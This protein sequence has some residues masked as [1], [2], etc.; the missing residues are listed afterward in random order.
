MIGWNLKTWRSFQA[1]FSITMVLAFVSCRRPITEITSQLGSKTSAND[2]SKTDSV[3]LV[4][5]QSNS[6]DP[7][8]EP[9]I[10]TQKD[11]KEDVTPQESEA[12]RKLETSEVS[13]LACA[14]IIHSISDEPWWYNFQN[15]L[16]SKGPSYLWSH[17][18][19]RHLVI[20]SFEDNRKAARFCSS[21][22]LKITRYQQIVDYKT[23]EL[24][25]LGLLVNTE[26]AASLL[27]KKYPVEAC[28]TVAMMLDPTN[29]KELRALHR[30]LALQNYSSARLI[31]EFLDAASTQVRE[32]RGLSI[33]SSSCIKALAKIDTV[34]KVRSL[35]AGNEDDILGFFS[36]CAEY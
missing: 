9:E 23:M 19:H 22:L 36:P 12:M 34:K 33:K 8:K 3:S 24:E 11:T 27:N 20:G 4:Q 28:M 26:Q 10:E 32:A 25:T 1:L 30:D 35:Q 14:G 16:K 6:Q 21:F 7:L 18:K 31:T 5:E 13:M 15:N 17:L 2:S 29:P